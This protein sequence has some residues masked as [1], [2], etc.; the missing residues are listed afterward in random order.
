MTKNEKLNSLKDL[1]KLYEQE[2]DKLLNENETI[3]SAYKDKK[4]EIILTANRSEKKFERSV[5][6]F[7]IS[8][9]AGIFTIGILGGS[10]VSFVL[11]CCLFGVGLADLIYGMVGLRKSNNQTQALDK[12]ELE[13]TTKINANNTL[14]KEYEVKKQK[15]S[16]LIDTLSLE[17]YHPQNATSKDYIAKPTDTIKCDEHT[18]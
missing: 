11:F 13:K 8:L 16:K 7:S 12:I 18:K 9:L 17:L 1:S 4:N 3:N 15:A 14:I 2:I 5:F 6:M 10:S